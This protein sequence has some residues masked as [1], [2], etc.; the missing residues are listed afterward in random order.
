MSATQNNRENMRKFPRLAQ[1]FIRSYDVKL[2]FSVCNYLVNAKK[3][4]W[5]LWLMPQIEKSKDKQ[6]LEFMYCFCV[7][8]L[9]HFSFRNCRNCQL[10]SFIRRISKG[11]SK[12]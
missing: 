11:R 9:V 2:S 10:V 6:E 12:K 7:K 4:V 1:V 3:P 5:I 8:C